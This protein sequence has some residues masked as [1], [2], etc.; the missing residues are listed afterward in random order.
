M[1]A[2][3]IVTT[4]LISF[5]AGMLS[6]NIQIVAPITELGNWPMFHHDARNSGYSSFET[7]AVTYTEPYLLWSYDTM[8]P[9]AGSP[10]VADVDKDGTKEVLIASGPSILHCF[11]ED[12]ILEWTF[13][14]ETEFIHFPTPA[15]GDIDGDGINE[16]LFKSRH[17][18][19][20]T[21]YKSCGALYCLYPDGTLKWKHMIPMWMDIFIDNSAPTIADMNSTVPGLEIVIQNGAFDLGIIRCISST[22]ELLWE[23]VYR[24][25]IEAWPTSAAPAIADLNATVLGLEIV[26]T[27]LTD[28]DR[29]AILCLNSKGDLLWRRD[30]INVISSCTIEDLDGDGIFEILVGGDGV[31]YC[32]DIDG[33]TIWSSTEPLDRVFSTP[34][35]SDV[36]I[37]GDKE[38]VFG[39]HD[40]YVYCLGFDGTLKWK[41]ETGGPVVSSPA[42]ADIEKLP[43]GQPGQL[44]IVVG[45]T[46]GNLYLLNSTGASI[47][48][49][50]VKT[51]CRIVASPAI[52][53]LYSDGLPDI[54]CGAYEPGGLGTIY[55]LRVVPPVTAK[56]D[57]EPDT[58]NVQHGGPFVMGYIEFPPPYDVHDI[59][60][61]TIQLNGSV[62][63]T[64]YDFQDNVLMVRFDR[65]DVIHLIN[66]PPPYPGESIYVTLEIIGNLIDGTP[67]QGNDTIHVINRG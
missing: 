20:D 19:T 9:V 54:V 58:L 5:L 28:Y 60:V 65:N 61:T 27:V 8:A 22:G 45:S 13:Q 66:P 64:D 37:D 18:L 6:C 47:W 50:E 39:S 43:G 32:L 12:G 10:V 56:I 67:F 33:E 53:D 51:G 26:T 25:Y 2:K 14:G 34:A 59:D 44:E 36:D 21:P 15:V 41:C 49:Y 30:D 48:T 35:I 31:V 1:K 16:I 4:I 11:D 55:A 52:V 46:D 63:I 62:P 23:H 57:I 3:T 17:P 24:P 42:L 29:G 40:N 7:S 38:I